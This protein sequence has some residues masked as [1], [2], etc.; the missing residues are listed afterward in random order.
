MNI[1]AVES[2]IQDVV[3][4]DCEPLVRQDRL[5]TIP[6]ILAAKLQPAILFRVFDLIICASTRKRLEDHANCRGAAECP[7]QDV[8]LPYQL[9]FKCKVLDEHGI[10]TGTTPKDVGFKQDHVPHDSVDVQNLLDRDARLRDHLRKALCPSDNARQCLNCLLGPLRFDE[11]QNSKQLIDSQSFRVM[12]EFCPDEVFLRADPISHYTPLQLAIT[13]FKSPKLKYALLFEVIKSLVERCPFS[14]FSDGEHNSKRMKAYQLLCSSK[15]D[16]NQETIEECKEWLKKKCIGY[17]Q[18]KADEVTGELVT[19]SLWDEK[20]ELL[21]WDAKIEKQFWLN[22][23][24]ES[25]VLDQFY[26]D[27]ITAQSGLRH[28]LETVLDIVRLPYWNKTP[29]KAQRYESEES[30]SGN[31]KTNEGVDDSRNPHQNPYVHIFNWLWDTCKVRKIFTLDVDD[32]GMEPHTN[33]AIRRSL[34]GPD[35]KFQD[36]PSSTRS[37]DIEV[38]K[39]KKFDICSDTLAAAAPKAR[40]VHLFSSGNIAVLKDWASKAGLARLPLLEKVYVEIRSQYKDDE[41]DCVGYETTFRTKLRKRCPKL[42]DHNNIQFSIFNS[43]G[44]LVGAQAETKS[45]T[46]S[47][48]ESALHQQRPKPK[49]W[50]EELA[51]FRGFLTNLQLPQDEEAVRARAVKVAILDDGARIEGL[52]GTQVGKTFDSERREYFAGKCNHGTEMA[53]CVRQICPMAELYIARLDTSR[54]SDPSNKFTIESCVK[55]LKWALE[56]DVDIISMCWSFE[57]NPSDEY[58]KRFE[59]LANKIHA[60]GRPILFGSLPDEGPTVNISSFA[61]VGLEGVIKISSATDGGAVSDA[62]TLAQFDFLFPGEKIVISNHEICEGSS[63]ATAYASG[64][65][66]LVLYAFKTYNQL[67]DHIDNTDAA[68]RLEAA[69][70]ETGMRDIFQTLAKAQGGEGRFVRPTLVIPSEFNRKLQAQKSHL[71]TVINRLMPMDSTYQR[72]RNRT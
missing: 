35:A 4:H 71:I 41:A 46:T 59:E 33:A 68:A 40:E 45:N 66:A 34:Q 6:L 64:L 1:P 56:L 9:S 42:A 60:T 70:T 44:S 5:G 25:V 11:G 47:N 63:F 30:L 55:A 39:W 7:L 67:C 51:A 36:E 14:M 49:Q 2:Y 50:V 54:K 17:S 22:L 10:R 62:N 8:P 3:L 19:D 65:A 26:I 12:L 32:G 29:D 43:S 13:L 53:R 20:E 57:R 27:T 15:T 52:K 61:P 72:Y 48:K 23:C 24:G 21:Y 69:R 58:K 28:K 38:W 16:E 31:S 37:F 18:K